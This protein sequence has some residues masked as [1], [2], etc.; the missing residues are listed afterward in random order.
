MHHCTSKKSGSIE[1]LPYQ[2]LGIDIKVGL[3]QVGGNPKLFR[4]LL[5]QFYVDHSDDIRLINIALQQGDND[6]AQRL[7]HTIKGVAATLGADE[8]SLRAKNVEIAI[9]QKQLDKITQLMSQLA[10]VMTPVFNGL[11]VLV[12]IES[13]EVKDVIAVSLNEDELQKLFDELVEMLEG[14]DPDAEDKALELTHQ[15]D[16]Q[17]SQKLLKQLT[18][19]VSHFDFD[20]ALVTVNQLR[21]T[22]V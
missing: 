16:Q 17:T 1:Y 20:E 4:K 7:A 18:Y 2:L 10:M 22:Q 12:S 15:L 19:Q 8:L 5:S 13:E 3:Q 6:T 11:S 14:M 21:S 9:K